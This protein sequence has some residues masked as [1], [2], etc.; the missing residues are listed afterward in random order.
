MSTPTSESA[1]PATRQLTLEERAAIRR[2]KILNR[3]AERMSLVTGGMS[4]SDLARLTKLT[5]METS[6]STTTQL[7]SSSSP[8][9]SNPGIAQSTLLP[10]SPRQLPDSLQSPTSTTSL[11]DDTN[12]SRTDCQETAP[13]STPSKIADTLVNSGLFHR[14]PHNTTTTTTLTNVESHETNPIDVT[15]TSLPSATPSLYRP[16]TSP[17]SLSKPL[18]PSPLPSSSPSSSAASPFITRL[19][20]LFTRSAIHQYTNY[21]RLFLL[22]IFA[23]LLSTPSRPNKSGRSPYLPTIVPFTTTDP[24]ILILYFFFLIEATTAIITTLA[25]L[26]LVQPSIGMTSPTSPI[27]PISPISPTS[28]TTPSFSSPL[29]DASSRLVLNDTPS[30][31][32]PSSSSSSSSLSTSTSSLV[33]SQSS[34][35]SG[36]Q[37]IDAVLLKQTGFDVEQLHSTLVGVSRFISYVH[38]IRAIANRLALFV[39]VI[40]VT[41]ASHMLFT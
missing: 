15:S 23:A 7:P 22:M 39:S 10:P 21:F 16:I 38:V 37:G 29:T 12:N 4:T 30:D 36:L 11:S 28:S 27:S 2:A 20:T 40:L 17:S 25:N 14:L 19:R 6:H 18:S 32:L 35:L 33:N 5:S 26:I 13:L 34:D 9:I 31:S 24:L 1:P 3:G 41:T 8:S